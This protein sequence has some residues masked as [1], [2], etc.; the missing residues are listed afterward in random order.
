[1]RADRFD[2]LAGVVERLAVLLAA[3]VP[4][5]SAVGYLDDPRVGALA[6]G[7]HPPDA[8]WSG[9]AA[10]WRVASEAGAPLASTLDR[11]ARSLRELGQNDRDARTA[12]AGPR[13]TARLVMVLPL[14]GVLFGLALGFDTLRVLFTTPLG[15]ACVVVGVLLLL[16]AHLW[17]RRLLARAARRDPLPGL[18]LDLVA[19]AVSGGASMPR[20]L[21]A[22]AR[23][24]WELGLPRADD[25]TI[26]ATLALSSRAGVPAAGLLRSA[27]E[28][29]RR[30]AR[31]AGERAAAT[32]GVTL[33]LPL[34]LCVLPSFMLLG[35]AP[36]VLAVL[37]STA[38]SFG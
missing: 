15:I 16:V 7:E 4:P 24:E 36:L 9:L 19:I 27:A 13:A 25:A 5:E 26:A 6:R 33:M 21:E 18:G 8:A 17:N 10:A 12:L 11:F 1:M 29:A 30:E 37:S 28:Q 34:G 32:L 23:V 20:A 22:V 31:S 14:V 3:G 2:E 35:V 38:G